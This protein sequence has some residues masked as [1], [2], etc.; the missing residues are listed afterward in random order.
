[1]KSKR[2][3]TQAVHAGETACQ[4]IGADI[5]QQ[6]AHAA[7]GQPVGDAGA[8]DA[9]TDDGDLVHGQGD[10]ARPGL[11]VGLLASEK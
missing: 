4:G 5:L 2:I 9:G 8:H 10:A 3:S 1:M 7:Q 6:H 11:F